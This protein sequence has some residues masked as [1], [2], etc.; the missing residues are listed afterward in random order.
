MRN[1]GSY[2]KPKIEELLV[3]IIV[4]E[5]CKVGI[6]I[7]LPSEMWVKVFVSFL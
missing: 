4:I 3:L 1:W 2:R 6:R 7:G 5:I